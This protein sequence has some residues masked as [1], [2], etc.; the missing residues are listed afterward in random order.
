MSQNNHSVTGT[1][2][3]HEQ[4]DLS[5][6]S[7]LLKNMFFSPPTQLNT[8]EINVK[9][10]EWLENGRLRQPWS[11]LW[12]PGQKSYK[13]DR[14]ENT[15]SKPPKSRGNFQMFLVLYLQ[16]SNANRII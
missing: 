9:G 10:G 6:Y 11:E 7:N 3:N 1:F 8:K 4:Y 14:E 16:S 13:E 2:S 12:K 5:L 15:W